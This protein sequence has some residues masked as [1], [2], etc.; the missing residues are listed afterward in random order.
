MRKL[1]IDVYAKSFIH[2]LYIVFVCGILVATTLIDK[3]N[4]QN[5]FQNE[6]RWANGGYYLFAILIFGLIVMFYCNKENNLLSD[7]KYH[8][9]LTSIFIITL[10]IQ[11][12]VA[13]WAPI[14]SGHSDFGSVHDMAINIANGGSLEDNEYFALHPNNANIAIFLSLI[15]RIGNSWRFVIWTGA[16]LTNLSVVMMAVVIKKITGN[17]VASIITGLIAEMLVALSWRAF[18]PYTDNF[19]MPFIAALILI[20][21][22][23]IRYEIK[24][25]SMLMIGLLGAWIKV[26]ALI[27]LIA[28]IVYMGIVYDL[29][30]FIMKLVKDSI[31]GNIAVYKGRI[32]SLIISCF[33][34]FCLS[35]ACFWVNN[36]YKIERSNEARGWQ[37]MFMVGQAY[38]N[39][40]QVGGNDYEE[41]WRGILSEHND[42]GDRL[43]A[44]LDQAISWIKERGIIGNIKFYI[45]KLNVAFNDGG[46][47][48]VQPYNHDRAVHNVIY[49][50]FSNDGDY[51]GLIVEIRQI[52]WDMMIIMLSVQILLYRFFEGTMNTVYVF[53]ELSIIGIIIYLFL[54]EGRSKYLYMFLP[55]ILSYAG[56]AMDT[57]LNSIRIIC[58]N[59]RSKKTGEYFG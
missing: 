52:L 15:Y 37:F 19:G 7:K 31:A 18:M 8:F 1:R 10:L 41:K 2:S 43:D 33:L 50:F 6:A 29:P 12:T 22:L 55:L 35:N 27:P 56:I 53:F 51:Y 21:V 5:T 30:A 13:L 59:I 4:A 11:T 32:I 44:C 17:K 34:L 14:I 49:H 57:A 38:E 20:F 16:F 36:R 3:Y 28:I 25:P 9:I 26:T 54:L 42:R 24:I 48:N 39:T 47:H 58:E 45:K 46:F 23:N 40:G